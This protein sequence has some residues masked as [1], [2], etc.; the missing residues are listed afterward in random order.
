M[1]SGLPFESGRGRVIGWDKGGA[2][3]V[4]LCS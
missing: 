4:W 3:A 2:A 1:M